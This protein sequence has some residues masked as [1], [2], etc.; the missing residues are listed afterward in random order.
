MQGFGC[1]RSAFGEMVTPKP[2]AAESVGQ[3]KAGLG[4]LLSQPLVGG[5]QVLVILFQP[6]EPVTLIVALEHGRGPLRVSQEVCRMAPTHVC[7]PTRLQRSVER[8]VAHRLQEPVT[9]SQW[10]L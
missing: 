10:C 3:P 1:E 9:A 8:K 7:E 4:R 2:E 5:P 6:V